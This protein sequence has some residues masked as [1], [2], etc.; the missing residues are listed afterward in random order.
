[1]VAIFVSENCLFI[2]YD[3]AVLP[4]L[5]IF[6]LPFSLRMI[7]RRI[8]RTSDQM[9]KCYTS[10]INN[11]RKDHFRLYMTCEKKPYIQ[12]IPMK[13]MSLLNSDKKISILQMHFSLTQRGKS[14]S[15][16]IVST[17][18][19]ATNIISPRSLIILP[20]RI[21]I[22]LRRVNISPRRIIVSSKRLIISRQVTTRCL[23]NEM[24][25]SRNAN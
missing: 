23:Q 11:D 24:S 6:R 3:N 15:F 19:Q 20:W 9:H 17:D 8:P 7:L 14:F 21:N 22:S 12:T 13:D 16:M 2:E 25:Y 18:M 5:P 4:H 10:G 1:M